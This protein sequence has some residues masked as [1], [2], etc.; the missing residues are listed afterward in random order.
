MTELPRM[1]RFFVTLISDGARS[2]DSVGSEMP[3]LEAAL[4]EARNSVQDMVME[5]VKRGE[6]PLSEEVELR[7]GDGRLLHRRRITV[8]VDDSTG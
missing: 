2:E 4:I 7:D 5:R 6:G 1:P 3:N 8:T